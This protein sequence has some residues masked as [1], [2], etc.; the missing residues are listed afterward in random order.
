MKKTS[1]VQKRKDIKSSETG[2]FIK[3]GEPVVPEVSKKPINVRNLLN[4]A[5]MVAGQIINILGSKTSNLELLSP[6]ELQNFKV[7]AEVLKTSR[8]LHLKTSALAAATR[9]LNAINAPLQEIDTKT[10]LKLTRGN[11]DE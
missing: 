7:A 11:R 2:R 10:L 8:E 4:D 3:E 1:A 5:C 9:D 6:H